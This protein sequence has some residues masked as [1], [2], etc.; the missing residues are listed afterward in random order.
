M[1]LDKNIIKLIWKLE[2]LIGSECYNPNS[3]DGW[4]GEEGRSFRYPVQ[5]YLTHEDKAP[6]KWWWNVAEK[7]EE[8]TELSVSTMKYKFGS[9]HLF[10]GNG[11]Y[12]VLSA[13]EE[14]YGID[15]NEL[16]EKL[17]D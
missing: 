6:S 8:L 10:I 14:R 3:Y 15:F 7:E 1:K 11:L 9:N 12:N 2:Y 4:T 5:Y 17:Q 13:L 16:E